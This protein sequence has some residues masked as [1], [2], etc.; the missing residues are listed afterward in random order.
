MLDRYKTWIELVIGGTSTD[1]HP[2]G[3]C[4]VSMEDS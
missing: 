1:A 4:M 2:I 3:R